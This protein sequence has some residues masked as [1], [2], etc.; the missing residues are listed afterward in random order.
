V[1]SHPPRGEFGLGEEGKTTSARRSARGRRRASRVD[2]R[3]IRHAV[4]GCLGTSCSPPGPVDHDSRDRGFSARGCA[5]AGPAVRS[6]VCVSRCGELLRAAFRVVLARVAIRAR[7][8]L[9]SARELRH[10]RPCRSDDQFV[11]SRKAD[12]RAAAPLRLAVQAVCGGPSGAVRGEQR[13]ARAALASQSGGGGAGRAL[14]CARRNCP[15]AARQCRVSRRRGLAPFRRGS[16]RY[17]DARGDRAVDVAARR[18]PGARRPGGRSATGLP[19]PAHGGRVSG[20]RRALEICTA[21]GANRR[22]VQCGRLVARCQRATRRRLVA[23]RALRLPGGRGPA[24]GCSRCDSDSSGY[25]SG[26]CQRAGP[27]CASA[28]SVRVVDGADL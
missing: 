13:L 22:L 16:A 20:R 2:G 12:L 14:V 26:R 9:E 19:H 8:A 6:N 1:R 23:R 28:Q 24:R 4:G 25:G 3:S 18:D 17:A 11:V 10:P 5:R 21:H 27:L 7:A 15:D